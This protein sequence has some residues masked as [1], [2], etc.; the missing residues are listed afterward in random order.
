MFSIQLEKHNYRIFLTVLPTKI[1]MISQ[2]QSM[3]LFVIG[4]SCFL[5]QINAVPK[6]SSGDME[7]ILNKGG[8][9]G[10]LKGQKKNAILLEFYSE[11]CGSC[12][13]FTP[14][15]EGLHK[16]I[17]AEKEDIPVYKV[18][19]DENAGMQLAN[20]QNALEDGIPNLRVYSLDSGSKLQYKDLI[21]NE[22]RMD[23]SYDSPA[24]ILKNAKKFLGSKTEL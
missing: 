9:E 24:K 2:I 12:K 19:I 5:P 7:K 17:V 22:Q 15:L 1:K 21:T 13:A 23:D 3:L 6:L 16:K 10:F 8:L 11:M 4:L 18:N 14:K 20:Q